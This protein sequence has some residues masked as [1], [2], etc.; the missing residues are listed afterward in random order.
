MTMIA[1][2]PS[3]RQPWCDIIPSWEKGEAVISCL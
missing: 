3:G 1:G 2:G